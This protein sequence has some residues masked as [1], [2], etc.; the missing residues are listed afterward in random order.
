MIQ[1]IC[2]NNN[3][4]KEY[5][6]G[7]TLKEIAND[8]K[9]S[10]E[11]PI[12]GAFVNNKLKEL[13][14]NIY[15]PK[16][17]EFI[18]ITHPEGVRM[19]VRSL[20][21]VLQ[22]AVNEVITARRLKIQH[23]ISNGFYCEVEGMNGSLNID[24]ILSIGEKMREIIEADFSFERFEILSTEAIDLFEKNE[25]SEKALLFKSRPQLYSSVYRLGGTIDYF[26]GYLVPST[27]YLRVFDLVKYYD[28]M[29]LIVPKNE[30]PNECSDIVTQDKL[31]EIFQE[32][33]NWGEILDVGYIGNIN[34]IVK[35]KKVS[36]LIQVSEALQE[37]KLS[38]IAD[39]IAHCE[40]H[41]K[42]ILISGP[43]S[44]GKTTFA[45][46]LAIQLKVLGLNPVTLSLDNYFVN[47]E[48]TP[49]DENGE[50]DFEALEALD[51]NLLNDNLI[52]LFKGEEVDLPKF[53]FQSGQRKYNGDRL[54]IDDKT[55]IIAEG[56]H[57]LNPQLTPR[58]NDHDKYRIYVSALTTVSLDNHNRIPTTDTR[59]V[60]RIV[61]DFRYR[62]YSALE[63]INRWQSVRK[64]EDKYIFPFQE[65]A[66]A[67]FNTAVHYEAGVLKRYVE[68]IL[69]EVPSNTP[70]YRETLRLLKF[71]SYVVP[72]ADE[73]IPPTSILR[74]FLGGSSLKY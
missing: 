60:R 25:L 29:L 47:R 50:Y 62:N 55:I 23:S 68:P 6:L 61:R 46:R 59:L 32:Y 39:N 35:N 30:D 10:L 7:T 53:S 13:S 16:I 41:P 5:P 11:F 14:Y 49:R 21:F 45:Q 28:G 33:K 73:E 9:V 15:K 40:Q 3:L 56:I 2:Q 38:Y 36:E 42:L 31:F 63:T 48:L 37:K 1:I 67:M 12:L 18:D 19:Y 72:I 66:D 65:N 8:L 70:A 20:S 17:V 52:R 71:F 4:K 34:E 74:E 22:K 57:A 69:H 43:S 27:G 24:I 26:F 44:S 51:V 54:K 64:G 58:I